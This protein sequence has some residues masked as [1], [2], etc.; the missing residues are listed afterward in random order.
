MVKNKNKKLTL[1]LTAQKVTHTHPF[2]LQWN[3]PDK[4]IGAAR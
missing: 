2:P 1:G 3:L 4:G